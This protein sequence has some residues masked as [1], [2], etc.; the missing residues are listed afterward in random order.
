MPS[1]KLENF[2]RRNPELAPL[3]RKLADYI[4][5]LSE[6]NI[7]ELIPRVAAAQLG[8]SEADTLGLLSLFQDAGIVEPRYHLVCKATGSVLG[9]YRSLDEVPDSIECNVCGKEHDSDDLRVD[10]AFEITPQGRAANA[11]A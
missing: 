6:Q 9:S 1:K 8:V 2:S 5:W 11:A 10:L 3:V 4:Q 7:K